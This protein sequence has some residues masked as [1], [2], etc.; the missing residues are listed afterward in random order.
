MYGKLDKN[1]N[2][3]LYNGFFIETDD[4]VITNSTD[5]DLASCGFKPIIGNGY[6]LQTQDSKI[7]VRYT[8]MGSY[9]LMEHITEDGYM[10]ELPEE[11][12]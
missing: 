5:A 9:I 1:G 7:T 2:I 10:G 11:D 6:V 4:M 12:E 8:D 3:T